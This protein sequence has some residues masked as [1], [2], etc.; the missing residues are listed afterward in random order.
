MLIDDLFGFWGMATD[1]A[2]TLPLEYI[3]EPM[4][5]TIGVDDPCAIVEVNFGRKPFVFRF[6]SAPRLGASI[7]RAISY[8]LFPGIGTMLDEGPNHFTDDDDDGEDDE[9][10]GDDDNE[11]FL[12]HAAATLDDIYFHDTTHRRRTADDSNNDGRHRLGADW[13]HAGE[14]DDD[15]DESLGG[16]SESD[17]DDWNRELRATTRTR[18][19]EHIV[20][21]TSEEGEAMWPRSNVVEEIEDEHEMALG[22]R[23]VAGLSDDDDDES[24][25]ER[26]SDMMLM[27]YPFG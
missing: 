5:P 19:L 11:H 1:I 12:A 18:S 7:T 8:I 16:E 23:G 14:Y 24:E 15:D 4:Y 2:V 22:S 26:A 6:E 20:G 27:G 21:S 10:D 9:S 13:H 3:D 25:D 17:L